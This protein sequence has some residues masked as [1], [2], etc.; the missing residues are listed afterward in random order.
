MAG[1]LYS[2][3]RWIFWPGDSMEGLGILGRWKDWGFWRIGESENIG[4]GPGFYKEEEKD[5]L[6]D[7]NIWKCKRKGRGPDLGDGNIFRNY[8]NGE[9]EIL[10]I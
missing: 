7:G 6:G 5:I 10:G 8:E 2:L 1:L 3:E 9:L 4:D